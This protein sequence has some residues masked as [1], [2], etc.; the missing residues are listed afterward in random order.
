MLLS[1]IAAETLLSFLELP[2]L[3]P[4]DQVL[5]PKLKLEEVEWNFAATKEKIQGVSQ[6]T[7]QEITR[8]I[9]VPNVAMARIQVYLGELKKVKKREIASQILR[10]EVHL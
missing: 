10:T 4:I 2:S 1:T 7:L 5:P 3:D 8:W 9:E 6:L